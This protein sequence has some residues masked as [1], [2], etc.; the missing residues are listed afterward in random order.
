MLTKEN[1]V[2]DFVIPHLN[3]KGLRKTLETIGKNTPKENVGKIILIDQNPDSY[4][5]VDDLVDIHIHIENQGYA[6]ACNL[7]IRLSDANFVACMND[8]VEIIHPKWIEGIIETFNRYSTALCVSPSSPRNPSLP[9]G[10]IVN[11]P[12]FSY[13]EEFTEEDY[14]KMV[15]KIGQNHIIDGI[16]MFFPIFKRDILEKIKGVIPG[17]CYFDEN[18]YPG[19]AEDYCLNRRAYLSGYRCLGSGLSFCWHWWGETR[20]PITGKTGVKFDK[21]FNEKYGIW[22]DGKLIE[23]ADIY[24]RTGNKEIPLNTI[25]E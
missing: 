14:D 5:Q 17:K 1:F 23:E 3:Y 6:R 10:P 19:G 20:H 4:Q 13:K 24:G 18:F 15:N 9:G 12:G 16:C 21:G 8:D 22:K 7:G 25:R 11:H 2:V